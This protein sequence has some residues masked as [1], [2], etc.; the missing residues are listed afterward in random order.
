LSFN[1]TK[2]STANQLSNCI[3]TRVHDKIDAL[4]EALNAKLKEVILYLKDQ[5]YDKIFARPELLRDWCQEHWANP[6]PS[7]AEKKRLGYL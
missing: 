3:E 5:D 2:S 4:Y 1:K 7:E 6:Y